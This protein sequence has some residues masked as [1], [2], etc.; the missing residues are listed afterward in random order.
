[1]FLAAALALAA[2]PDALAPRT[3]EIWAHA[4]A[5]VSRQI[6]RWFT[7]GDFPRA[8]GLLR[9]QAA[10]S[11]NDYD[12]ATNLGWLLQ[13]MERDE[14]ALEAYARYRVDNPKD[15]DNRLPEAMLYNA[16]RKYEKVIEVLEPSIAAAT[17]TEGPHPNVYRL[18]AKSYERVGRPEDA[19]RVWNLQLARFPDDLPAKANIARVKAKMAKGSSRA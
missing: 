6:D 12:V 9:L 5:R 18:L 16:R 2:V 10:Y 13:S 15:R 4:D 14:D 11:P 8:V 3:D 1:M 19:I 17:K 7:D